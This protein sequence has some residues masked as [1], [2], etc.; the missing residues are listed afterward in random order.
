MPLISARPFQRWSGA[1]WL[2]AWNFKQLPAARCVSLAFVWTTVHPKCLIRPARWDLVLSFPCV[3]DDSGSVVRMRYD[4]SMV[5]M[6]PR[7]CGGEAD[8]SD[9]LR[10]CCCTFHVSP[11]VWLSTWVTTT[12]AL[13][14]HADEPSPAAV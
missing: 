12:Q 10:Y 13:V 1:L 14:G 8:Q 3:V 11:L 5:V 7:D 9:G 6:V 4:C 2:G